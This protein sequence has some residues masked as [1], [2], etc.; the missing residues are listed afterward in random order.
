[1]FGTTT[2]VEVKIG[3]DVYPVLAYRLVRRLDAVGIARIELDRS[4]GAPAIN[5]HDCLGEEATLRFLDPETSAVREEIPLTVT[6]ASERQGDDGVPGVDLELEDPLWKLRRRLQTRMFQDIE[7]PQ[8]VDSLLAD[9]RIE[10]PVDFAGAAAAPKRPYLVQYDESDFDFLSRVLAEDGFSFV[11]RYADGKAKLFVT[12]KVQSIASAVRKLP[13]HGGFGNDGLGERIAHLAEALSTRPGAARVGGFDP[14]RPSLTI[15]ETSSV[16]GSDGELYVPLARRAD[17]AEA[18]AE[19]ARLVESKQAR[20]RVIEGRT[21]ASGLAPGDHIE[22]SGHPYEPLNGELVIVELRESQVL[23]RGFAVGRAASS[24]RRLVEFVALPVTAVIR[25]TNPTR[26]RIMP[27]VTT[28]VTTGPSGDEI[29]TNEH[30][31]VT[32]HFHWDRLGKKDQTSSRFM[33]TSQLPTAGSMLLPRVGWEVVVSHHE[34]DVDQP[35]V[36]SRLY[37]GAAMPPY[38]LPEGALRSSI[39]TATTPG[40]GSTNEIRM[41]DTKGNEQM[42]LN[43]SKDMSVDIGNNTTQSVGNDL[44]VEVGANQ[45]L[46]VIDSYKSVVGANETTDVGGNQSI[47]VAKLGVDDV[48]G[49]HEHSVAGKRIQMIGGDLRHTVG[50]NSRLDVS[51]NALTAAIGS[52]SL[53]ATGAVTHQVG[54]ALVEVTAGSK[55][56]AVAQTHS[57]TTGA[58]KVLL[59]QG[60]RAVEAGLL[61]TTVGG[62]VLAKISGSRVDSADLAWSEMAGGVEKVE[63]AEIVIEGQAMVSLTMG[64]ATV[65]LTP[66]SISIAGADVKVDGQL[67]QTS[68]MNLNN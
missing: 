46:T 56:Y 31:E 3:E 24:A 40:G 44:T 55:S 22:V 60:A 20:A 39:Q 42:M 59:V 62:A 53:D 18:Q 28:A 34:G 4:V 19:A 26:S 50:G 54:T 66:A 61:R 33:R 1:M 5:L 11:V 6:E 38:S 25:P 13:Y 9:A 21:S 43:A 41:D 27:G 8:L 63:A 68:P 51:G 45:S 49:S 67:I 12:N 15:Q 65:T 37:N 58:A 35:V 47:S 29:H 32:V 57:E 23:A 17:P 48:G 14:H 52:V 7:L 64:G 36:M 16:E 10:I 2:K 30:G